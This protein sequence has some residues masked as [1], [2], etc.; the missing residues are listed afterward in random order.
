M[1]TANDEYRDAALRHQIGLRQYSAGLNKRVA[2]LLEKADQ[3]LSAMLRERLARL[4]AAGKTPDFTSDRWKALLGDIRE[5]RAQALQVVNELS[6]KELTKLS[7]MEG[8]REVKLLDAS[9]P[10]AYEFATVSADQLR[11][12]L[13]SKPFQ[14]KLLKDWFSQLKRVDQHRLTAAIQ[15]GMTEGEPIDTMVR[16]VVGTAAQGYSDGILAMTRRD[17]TAIVRTAVNHVSNTARQYVWDANQDVITAMVW[18][19]T[20]DG[21]TT[22]ICRARDGQMA[23]VGDNPLPKGATPLS[24]P[25]AQPPAH[26]NCRSIMVAYINGTG[27]VG[28]RPYVTDTRTRDHREVDFRQIAKARGTT[29]K[30]VRDSWAARNIGQ[31]PASTTYQEFLSRQPASFQDR[32][33]GPTRGKLFRSGNLKLTQFVD[34]SGNELTLA[35][36]ADTNPEAFIKAGFDPDDF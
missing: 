25:G 18:H 8:D 3:D 30:S 14:G 24:P 4:F 21:R 36:L 22:P 17:A 10:I 19:A 26:I 23:P 2:A 29:V 15:L 33:L 31:V 28:N 11:A 34:R 7:T 35:Q 12:I 6:R 13:S 20:L 1:G 32:V 16:R 9:V 27:L 5:A